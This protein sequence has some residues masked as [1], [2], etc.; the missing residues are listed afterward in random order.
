MTEIASV[1]PG[2]LLDERQIMVGARRNAQ[3]LEFERLRAAPSS[4]HTAG[5]EIHRR[6]QHDR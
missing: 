4:R 1:D 2:D 6:H 5:S 3:Q